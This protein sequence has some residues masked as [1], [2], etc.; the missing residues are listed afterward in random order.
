M[1]SAH[2]H[3][4]R[5]CD[6]CGA[7]QVLIKRV[8]RGLAYCERCYPKFFKPGFCARCGE[9]ARLPI[10]EPQALCRHCLAKAPCVRCGKTDYAVGKITPY[11][12]VCTSCAHHFREPK[13]CENCG[14]PSTR[15]SRVSA[16][17][18]GLRLCPACARRHHGICQACRRHRKLHVADDGRRLC[19]KCMDGGDVPCPEC[20]Q[21]MPA[22]RGN[23]CE[24]CYW[25]RTFKK[26]LKM[27]QSA[28]KS[29]AVTQA[30]AHFGAWLREKTGAMKAA[31]V[32]NKHLP[33][34][35]D[36]DQRWG[37]MPSRKALEDHFGADGMSRQ[38]RVSRWLVESSRI[39]NDP[40]AR[41]R[42]L[43]LGRIDRIVASVPAGTAASRLLIGYRDRVMQRVAAGRTS[44]HSARL[45]LVPAAAL[46]RLADSTGH[47]LPGPEDV[48]RYLV[49]SLGQKAA[50]TGFVNFLRKN[51]EFGATPA[52]EKKRDTMSARRRLERDLMAMV[53]EGIA[54]ETRL[55]Q[56]VA[57][58]LAYFHRLPEKV[59]ERSVEKMEIKL[60]E[61]GY[62]V[63]WKEKVYWV[64]R[65]KK[66]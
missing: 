38:R 32:I 30:F 43:A 8:H 12:P 62:A 27:D 56:W 4:P 22:G 5:A 6:A 58:S 35:M 64:P 40:K 33:F 42:A 61:E 18:D 45:A 49:E 65:L 11:G 63:R 31:L 46:L 21:P 10:D 16:I 15:L 60:D 66:E 51:T 24:P 57:K 34:F 25:E 26:R 55:R 39:A 17:N 9:R 47:R 19:R 29:D 28:L 53:R 13:P 52:V 54:D 41:E 2:G 14:K 44:L 7:D 37:D 3:K 1:T 48:A 59:C 36:V 23:L 20:G 50:I